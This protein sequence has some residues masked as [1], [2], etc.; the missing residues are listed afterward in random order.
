MHRIR[1]RP[2]QICEKEI[3][4]HFIRISHVSA[5]TGGNVPVPD[6]AGL[7]RIMP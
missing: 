6:Y 1:D 5:V 7:C 4:S 2:E 3:I